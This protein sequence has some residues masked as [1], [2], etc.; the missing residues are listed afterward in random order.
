MIRLALVL[1]GV[2]CGAIPLLGVWSAPCAHAQGSSDTRTARR[3]YIEGMRFYNKKRYEEAK[4]QLALAKRL[5]PKTKRYTKAHE[6]LSY[7]LGRCHFALKEYEAAKR[8]LQSFLQSKS[9]DEEKRS[10]ATKLLKEAKAALEKANKPKVIVV[11][12][13]T[14]PDKR[15]TV[16]VIPKDEGGAT[17][18]AGPW[19]VWPFL[20]AGV[21]VLAAGAGGLM[22]FLSMNAQQSRDQKYEELKG[23]ASGTATPPAQEVTQLHSQAQ[24]FALTA[25]ALYI[26]GGVIAA[27]GIVLILT[28]GRGPAPA[29]KTSQA[30]LPRGIGKALHHGSF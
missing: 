28:V 27:T 23:T 14:K 11:P 15:V 6:K 20:I 19:R 12:N 2:L 13:T 1:T 3:I 17:Q 29:T 25:N 5:L 7:Y 4:V 16:V 9:T 24:T 26:G 30:R 8:H 22:G 18:K 21:G 10:N